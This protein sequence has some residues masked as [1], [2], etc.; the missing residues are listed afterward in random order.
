VKRG[1]AVVVTAVAIIV[2]FFTYW[3]R[4]YKWLVEYRLRALYRRLRKLELR[5]QKS[6]TTS[7][8]ST[9]EDE[10]ESLD[11]DIINL[12]V[13]MK[14]SDLYFMIKSHL[15]L[16]RT[17]IGLRRSDMRGKKTARLVR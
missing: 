17:R 9:L 8:I 4:L 12:G 6:L 14:H 10:I 16:V 15:N 2:P 7:E 13:P 1:I 3:P 11:Q 5:L